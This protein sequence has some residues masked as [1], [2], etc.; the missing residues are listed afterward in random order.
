MLAGRGTLQSVAFLSCPRPFTGPQGAKEESQP[1]EARRRVA[2]AGRQVL[3]PP[4]TL[5]SDPW[6]GGA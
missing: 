6:V 5:L 1:A 4:R 2:D 3:V